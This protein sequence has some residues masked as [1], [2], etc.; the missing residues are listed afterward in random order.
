MCFSSWTF[1]GMD[2]TIG[3]YEQFFCF[4]V[5][6]GGVFYFLSWTAEFYFLLYCLSSGMVV[7]YLRSVFFF[8]CDQIAL[9]S[10]QHCHGRMLWTIEIWA[11]GP[12]AAP[13]ARCSASVSQPSRVPFLCSAK[14]DGGYVDWKRQLMYLWLQVMVA[15]ESQ[16]P[17]FYSAIPVARILCTVCLLLRNSLLSSQ[18]CR[19][20]SL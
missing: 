14:K 1:T 10:G 20:S 16:L 17:C 13:V 7:A 5:Y 19:Y 3:T 15:A 18:G 11:Y 2:S 9:V 6:W 8:L 4:P 12:N